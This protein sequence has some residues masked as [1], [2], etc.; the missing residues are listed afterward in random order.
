LKYYIA[1]VI[2]TNYL[3]ELQRHIAWNNV[4]NYGIL[5]KSDI[6]NFY[7]KAVIGIVV[8]DYLPNLGYKRGTLGSNKLFEYM[9][10]GLPIICTDYHLWKEIIEKYE[11]G[12]CVSP[13]NSFEI[14]SAIRFLLENKERAY[15]MGQNGK[16]AVKKYY[17]W[18]SQEKIYTDLFLKYCN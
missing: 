7:K 8:Y 2:D 12:I 1:G 10:A 5:H 15:Q 13:N 3:T 14:E 18:S 4:R 16:F 11:C 17:N 6:S 9:E